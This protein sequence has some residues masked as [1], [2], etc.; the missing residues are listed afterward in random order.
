[1]LATLANPIVPIF[2]VLALGYGFH[3][4]GLFEV[5]TAQAINRFVFFVSTPALVFS[6]ISSAP[7]SHFDFRALGI[8]LMAQMLAYGGIYLLMSRVFGYEPAEA[9]LLGMTAAFVNHVFF[10]LPIAER[11]YGA[12][13]AQPIAKAVLVSTLLSLVSLSMLTG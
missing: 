6:I 11:L 13:A 7:V 2:A 8:Y 1:V 9:L 5:T 10:V 3:R 4:C 12:K